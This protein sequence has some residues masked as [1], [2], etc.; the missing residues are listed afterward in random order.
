MMPSMSSDELLVN[1]DVVVDEDQN[2]PLS[3]ATS[4]VSSCGGASTFR[5]TQYAEDSTGPG[6][7]RSRVLWEHRRVVDD[8]DLCLHRSSCLCGGKQR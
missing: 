1:D 8:N 7:G 3:G 6:G 5:L 2:L 4:A